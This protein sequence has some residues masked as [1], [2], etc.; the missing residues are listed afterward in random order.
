MIYLV[1]EVDNMFMKKKIAKVRQSYDEFY[2]SSLDGNSYFQVYEYYLRKLF[3]NHFV[4]FKSS[5]MIITR[6]FLNL[7][8]LNRHVHQQ[9]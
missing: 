9:R 1:H 5:E 6:D 8:R 3:S 4:I 2:C 7:S